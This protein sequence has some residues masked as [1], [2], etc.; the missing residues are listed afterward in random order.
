MS[1]WQCQNGL[2]AKTNTRLVG[3]VVG[4]WVDLYQIQAEYRTNREAINH[5]FGLLLL[6]DA[7]PGLP[8]SYGIAAGYILRL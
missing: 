7:W 6:F 2:Q 5:L 8:G 1:D 4:H 3:L